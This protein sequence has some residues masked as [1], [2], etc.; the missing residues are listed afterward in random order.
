VPEVVESCGW[1]QGDFASKN[2]R[3]GCA[4]TS[5]GKESAGREGRILAAD[6]VSNLVKRVAPVELCSEAKRGENVRNRGPRLFR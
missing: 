1:T 6:H 2:C 3:Y 4:H 5:I